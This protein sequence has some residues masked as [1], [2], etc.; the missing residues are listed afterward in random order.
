VTVIVSPTTD[1]RVEQPDQILL[2]RRSI[3]TNLTTHLLQEGVHV[4]LGGCN[5]E[6]AAKEKARSEKKVEPKPAAK[7]PRKAA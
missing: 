3:R 1:N 4:L 2:L 7:S 5:Q 6:F